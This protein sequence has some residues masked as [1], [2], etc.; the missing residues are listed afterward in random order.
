MGTPGFSLGSQM[1]PSIKA[2]KRKK[3]SEAR[4]NELVVKADERFFSSGIKIEDVH[5]KLTA[6]GAENFREG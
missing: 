2:N 6:S 1:K 4:A 5:G 3:L